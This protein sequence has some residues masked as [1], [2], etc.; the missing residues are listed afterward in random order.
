MVAFALMSIAIFGIATFGIV[1]T[2][3][4]ADRARAAQE[5]GA[6]LAHAVDVLRLRPDVYL[7]GTPLTEDAAE[8]GAQLSTRLRD[9][10]EA[11]RAL[12]PSSGDVAD[13]ALELATRGERVFALLEQG[14]IE[15][16]ARYNLFR[17]EPHGEQVASMLVE[18]DERLDARAADAR[19]DGS[20]V[21]VVTMGCA[22]TVMVIVALAL[23]RARRRT[24]ALEAE[25]HARETSDETYR[26]LMQHS[27][28]L[29]MI[30]DESWTISFVSPTSESI[31]GLAPHDLVGQAVV[32]MLH[33]DDVMRMA[34]EAE[35]GS[36]PGTEA[37]STARWRHADGEWRW[38]E[39]SMADL[40]SHPTIKGYVV[41]ARDVTRRIDLEAELRQSQK[42][43]SVGQL[44]SGIAHEINTPVQ[45][46]GDNIRFFRDAFAQMF[47]VLDT[48]R[49]AVPAERSAALEAAEQDA[50]VDYF[51]GELPVAL[52]QALAGVDRIAT[53]VRAMR[54]FGHP[55]G[56]DQQAVDINECVENTLTVARNE[57]K[58]V[59][60]V[61]LDLGELP[62]VRCFRG[63]IN[64]VL[65]NMIVNAAHAIG[66]KV[67]PSGELGRIAVSTRQDGDDEVVIRIS[68]TGCG[69]PDDVRSRIF[70]PFFTTKGVGRGTG[71]GLAIARSL[72]YERHRGRIVCTSTV[73]EGTTFEIYLPINGVTS[74]STPNKEFASI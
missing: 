67:G 52:D 27:A 43:E 17:L 44:A 39:S 65:L 50:E 63:D 40:R 28:D 18:N 42:L 57:V 22:F 31:L 49:A 1:R 25:R 72:I 47:T 51:R 34:D 53:I 48:Y 74:T 54:S 66:E 11:L 23:G 16:A 60:D 59:A 15:E 21:I 13:A 64:Q 26:A 68:D 12:D 24:T 37:P 62:L 32:T 56:A 69:I 46:V 10:A 29:T 9:E 4:R 70:D 20:V 14:D 71:Q 8:E 36:L 5:K 33:P 58:H 35:A 55:D 30:V 73:G 6:E 61:A 38:I 41:N 45:F 3:L 7:S 2:F 19:R